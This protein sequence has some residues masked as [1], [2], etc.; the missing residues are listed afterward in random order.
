MTYNKAINHNK[1][2]EMIFTGE[3]VYS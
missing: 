2:Q 3:F 1:W